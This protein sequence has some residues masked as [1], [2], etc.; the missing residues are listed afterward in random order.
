MHGLRTVGSGRIRVF[1][2][3]EGRSA[4]VSANAGDEL[5]HDLVANFSDVG[6]ERFSGALAA[7]GLEFGDVTTSY[8]GMTYWVIY[9]Q[10]KPNFE[11]E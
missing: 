4:A 3:G 6:L 1:D 9:P 10:G 8:E 2:V 7:R 11:T 5:T